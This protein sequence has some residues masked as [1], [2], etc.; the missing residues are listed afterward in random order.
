MGFF[1]RDAANQKPA[2]EAA[3]TAEAIWVE[4]AIVHMADILCLYFEARSTNSSI[5]HSLC[6][7]NPRSQCAP[8]GLRAAGC[9]DP[10]RSVQPSEKFDYLS[11]VNICTKCMFNRIHVRPQGVGGQLNTITQPQRDGVLAA[12]LADPIGWDQ[13]SVGINRDKG[14]I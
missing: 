5:D 14:P 2:A 3:H 1:V 12:A 10:D 8:R 6:P 4:N 7:V 9:T 13:L 11:I